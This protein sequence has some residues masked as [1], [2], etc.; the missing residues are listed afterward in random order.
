MSKNSTAPWE[1]WS[2]RTEKTLF[3]GASGQVCQQ[4]WGWKSERARIL[5]KMDRKRIENPEED[6][7][8][9][10]WTSQNWRVK[11][12]K[13]RSNR[14]TRVAQSVKR[15]TSAQVMIS[16][17]VSSSPTLG[18]VLSVQSLELASDSVSPS[19]SAPRQLTLC[20]YQKINKC[21]APGWLSRLSGFGSG[22]NLVVRGFK[23]RVR[24]CADSSEPGACSR[25]SVSLSLCPS[26]TLLSLK[27]K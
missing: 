22:H 21:G 1:S 23:P 19:L 20:L 15:P 6:K 24:L 2:V 17:S 10:D 26:P 5:C 3:W 4:V 8:H 14:G 13:N 11:S 18:S 7:S 9:W 25:F 27:N 16:R 12:R